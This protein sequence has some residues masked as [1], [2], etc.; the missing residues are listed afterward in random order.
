M[1]CYA[2]AQLTQCVLR[3]SECGNRQDFL[4][5]ATDNNHNLHAHKHCHLIASR[6]CGCSDLLRGGGWIRPARGTTTTLLCISAH[7]TFEVPI[8]SCSASLSVTGA[9]AVA[10]PLVLTTITRC[11]VTNPERTLKL[12]TILSELP[13]GSQLDTYRC[14][15]LTRVVASTRL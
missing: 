14:S 6:W 13:S 3:L 12:K 8:R 9:L 5:A 4:A 15:V 7:G 2:T 10:R 1:V 11:P